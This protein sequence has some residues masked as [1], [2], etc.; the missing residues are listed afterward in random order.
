MAISVTEMNDV[1]DVTKSKRGPFA[2]RHLPGATLDLWYVVGGSPGSKRAKW[3][4]TTRAD[5]A[6]TQGA[7]VLT[8]MADPGV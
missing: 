3:V 8:A 4:S 1:C 6:A 7:A 2:I 5:D